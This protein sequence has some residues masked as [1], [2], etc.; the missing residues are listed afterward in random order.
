MVDVLAQRGD[1]EAA[2]RL[3]GLWNEILAEE[4]VELLCSYDLDSLDAASHARVLLDA[5]ATHS[6]LVPEEGATLDA[7]VASAL[8]DVFGPDQGPVLMRVL[9][10]RARLLERMSVGSA[11]LV[12]LRALD[13]DAGARVHARARAHMRGLALTPAGPTAPR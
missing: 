5:C 1:Y 2:H 10:T 3:E 13:P 4:D 6:S 7:A 8:G 11:I 9:P 12:S